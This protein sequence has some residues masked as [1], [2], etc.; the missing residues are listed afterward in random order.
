MTTL[1]S[2]AVRSQW[3]RQVSAEYRSSA[4]AQQLTL[5]LTQIGASPDLIDSG[6]R[7]AHDELD[8]SRE[9]YEVYRAAGGTG[10]VSLQRPRLTNAGSDEP[11]ELLVLDAAVTVFCLGETVAVPLFRKL[12]SGCDIAV[13]RS[14]L[15]RIVKDEPRHSSFGWDLLD[16]LLDGPCTGREERVQH[17]LGEGFRGLERAYGNQ[18]TPTAPTFPDADRSW[19]LAPRQEYAEILDTTFHRVWQ[20]RFA[21]YGIDTDAAWNERTSVDKISALRVG[22]DVEHVA[23]GRPG[24]QPARSVNRATRRIE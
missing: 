9:S 21:A 3:A 8:H 11:L 23:I 18:G 16:W 17:T 14:V 7:I 20:R 24:L 1:A 19:G 22:D 2:D 12:R 15:D 13:P 6:L 4:L 10:S 5:W